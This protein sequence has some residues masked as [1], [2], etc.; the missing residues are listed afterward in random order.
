MGFPMSSRG[1]YSEAGL[2]R[3]IQ[4]LILA[5]FSFDLLLTVYNS[6]SY[7]LPIISAI[8]SAGV[9]PVF[10]V[11]VSLL[12]GLL[13]S[14]P[15]GSGYPGCQARPVEYRASLPPVALARCRPVLSP[16]G[17]LIGL[18]LALSV[19]LAVSVGFAQITSG[20]NWR[21]SLADG[22]DYT[23]TVALLGIGA[24]VL[25]AFSYLPQI[26]LGLFGLYYGARWLL[27][28][29]RIP[30]AS[31]VDPEERLYRATMRLSETP[32]GVLTAGIVYAGLLST[33]SVILSFVLPIL[34]RSGFSLSPRALVLNL[35]YIFGMAFQVVIF[36]YWFALLQRAPYSVDHWRA[37]RFEYATQKNA[38]HR[39]RPLNLLLPTVGW[40][41]T[42][43]P[44]SALQSSTGRSSWPCGLLPPY[45]R[46]WHFWYY[47]WAT[48]L[49]WFRDSAGSKFSPRWLLDAI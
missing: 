42:Q 12:K 23:N 44:S 18:Y 17:T 36:Y 13:L 22:L 38:P 37:S 15:A 1:S 3:S 4:G 28:K 34:V 25:S 6:L 27:A 43:Y 40:I 45:G 35:S 48:P 2:Q 24:G 46:S 8:S 5:F 33:T 29:A 32:T 30:D 31:Q 16:L 11:Q 21:S 14:G 20:G 39:P 26:L 47:F 19:A 10:N 49:Y 41:L 7:F 9:V